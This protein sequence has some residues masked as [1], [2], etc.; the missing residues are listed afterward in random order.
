MY[1]GGLKHFY[2]HEVCRL[3]DGQLVLPL[4][5]IKHNGKLSADC[6]L[7]TITTEVGNPTDLDHELLSN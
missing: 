5:W 6:L 4:A 7:V 1:A 2:I 3:S